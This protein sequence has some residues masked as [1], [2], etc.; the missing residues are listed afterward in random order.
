MD[1]L[2]WLCRAANRL[3]QTKPGSWFVCLC[4]DLLSRVPVFLVGRECWRLAGEP[5]AL[6]NE[7]AFRLL[8][9]AVAGQITVWAGGGFRGAKLEGESQKDGGTCKLHDIQSSIINSCR[10]I[11]RLVLCGSQI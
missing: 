2:V 3:L 8:H 4:D 9:D 5:H 11:Q 6:G 7:V 1:T 10:T